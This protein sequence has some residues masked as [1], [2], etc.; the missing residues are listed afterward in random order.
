MQERYNIGLWETESKNKLKYCNGKVF[1]NN[2]AYKVL[3]FR[4]TKK[5]TDKHPDFTVVLFKI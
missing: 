4:N 5:K 1:I 3:L 2:V